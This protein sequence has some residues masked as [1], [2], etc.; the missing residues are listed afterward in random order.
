VSAPI[1]W[2]RRAL[3]RLD[4]IGA[5]IAKN[6]QAAAERV[7]EEIAASIARLR[8]LPFIG[9]SGRIAGTRELAVPGIRYIVAYRVD[10]GT[11][12]VLA[13]LHNAQEWRI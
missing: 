7:V 13:I 5:H 6:N 8:N 2:P 3:Q 9:R 4:E 1:R 10:G 12:Q 11:V